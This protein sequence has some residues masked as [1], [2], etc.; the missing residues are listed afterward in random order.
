LSGPKSER[1]EIPDVPF[2]RFVDDDGV[3]DSVPAVAGPY[4]C[5]VIGTRDHLVIVLLSDETFIRVP[6]TPGTGPSFEEW[7][8]RVRAVN[9]TASVEEFRRALRRE[10]GMAV[11]SQS[12]WGVWR[13]TGSEGDTKLVGQGGRRA[14]LPAHPFVRFLDR[15]GVTVSPTVCEDAVIGVVGTAQYLMICEIEDGTVARVRVHGR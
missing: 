4:A 3:V 13:L 11:P 2:A 1:V 9:Q 12:L 10:L 5:A 14:D 8:R 15:R 7:Q 6:R